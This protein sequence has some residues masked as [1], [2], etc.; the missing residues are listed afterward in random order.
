MFEHIRRFRQVHLLVV[1]VVFVVKGERAGLLL[2]VVR[3]VDLSLD[4]R[5]G[6]KHLYSLD[7]V[8]ARH[9]T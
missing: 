2:G 4:G 3:D 6:A 1:V 7:G 5:R 8:R 9:G